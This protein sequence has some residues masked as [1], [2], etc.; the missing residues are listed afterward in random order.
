MSCDAYRELIA[1]YLDD[2]L[3]DV[4]RT[5]FR[6]HLRSCAECRAYAID[7]EP[8]LALV[9]GGDR[10]ADPERIESCV[11][12]VMAGI[13]RDR[14]ER[15]LRPAR[16]PWLA[17]AAAVVIAVTAASWWWLAPPEAE[18]TT[19][20]NATAVVVQEAET[21]VEIA[22]PARVEPPRVEVDMTQEEVRVYRYAIGNDNS[23]G[24]IF[25]VNPAMEL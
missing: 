7:R 25:I 19:D 24:A 14:L 20:L 23:T 18:I 6:A 12:A 8:T 4:R 5:G 15:R 10:L 21:P 22:P 3:D 11:T 9:P 1:A 17:A 13:R 16:R 2:T